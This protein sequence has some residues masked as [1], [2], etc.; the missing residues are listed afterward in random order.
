MKRKTKLT[1][2]GLSLLLGAV[3]LSGCTASFCSVTDKAHILYAFDYGV[4]RY[5]ADGDTNAVMY[6]T[7]TTSETGKKLVTLNNV[8]YQSYAATL[9]DEELRNEIYTHCNTYKSIDQNA[10]KSGIALPGIKF[11]TTLD[12]V[13][14]GHAV[15]AAYADADFKQL[16]NLTT[17]D[18]AADELTLQNVLRDYTNPELTKKDKGVLDIYGYLKYEDSTDNKKQVL[19]TNFDT[20]IDETKAI[21]GADAAPTSDYL[22][23]YKSTLNTKISSL[24]SCLA[25]TTDDYGAYGPRNQAVEIQGKAITDWR[26]LLEF[27]FVWPIGAFIDVLTK[28]F[29][30][31]GMANGWA[32]VLSIFIVT[33]IIRSLMLL[34]TFKQTQSSAKMNELQPEIQKIQAKYPNS[35]TNQYDKQRMAADMQKLYKKNKINPL[36]TMLVMFV[37]FPIFICVWGAMQGSAYLSSGSLLG[38]RLSD[39]IGSTMMSGSSWANGGGATALV[40]FLLMAAAQTV[41]MLLPQWIQKKKAKAVAKLGKNPAQQSQNNKMKWFTWIMLGMIIFMGF[42]LASGMG[43]YWLIGA[44]FSVAQTLIT[45]KITAKA[46]SKHKDNKPASKEKKSKEDKKEKVEKAPKT[47]KVKDNND[48]DVVIKKKES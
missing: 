46:N 36:G 47:E 25:T 22:K 4:T 1:L 30:G 38:L 45:Q 40:L 35:N 33:V 26:G 12:S 16:W 13:V 20:Y 37:Q 21:I 6:I 19:W 2:G 15:E 28:A 5:Q 7:D 39:S 3:V 10:T 43:V 31:G 23:L 14:L 9:T 44:L 41:S 8:K 11:L 24:R 34:V 42:S 29:L 27:C 18:Q 48:K 17:I 32:Q